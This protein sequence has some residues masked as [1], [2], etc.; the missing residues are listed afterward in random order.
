MHVWSKCSKVWLLAD[1]LSHLIIIV[2]QNYF[3]QNYCPEEIFYK[4]HVPIPDFNIV[5]LATPYVFLN[6]KC[7]TQKKDPSNCLNAYVTTFKNF[8]EFPR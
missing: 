1:P 3:Y 6:T 2:R 8:I 5:F 4:T 7:F